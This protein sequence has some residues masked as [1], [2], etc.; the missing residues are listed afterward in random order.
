MLVENA[1]LRDQYR[2]N[3]VLTSIHE[4]RETFDVRVIIIPLCGY[5]ARIAA[6]FGR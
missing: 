2:I 4:T 3:M 6:S 5:M 1:S